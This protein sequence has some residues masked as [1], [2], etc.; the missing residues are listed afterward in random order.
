[1]KFGDPLFHNKPVPSYWYVIKTM[2]M[3][4]NTT[5]CYYISHKYQKDMT[6]ILRTRRQTY[7]PLLKSINE[8]PKLVVCPHNRMMMFPRFT[9]IFDEHFTSYKRINEVR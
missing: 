1:M 8:V 9:L 3:V 6:T 5:V 7:T 2:D 4:D